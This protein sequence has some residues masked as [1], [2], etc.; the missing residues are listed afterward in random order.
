MPVIGRNI[1]YA[2]VI[3][4]IAR[5]FKRGFFR[6]GQ[7]RRNIPDGAQ[8]SYPVPFEHYGGFRFREL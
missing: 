5:L 3:E 6:R 2:A 4:N 1:A 8:K 7:N